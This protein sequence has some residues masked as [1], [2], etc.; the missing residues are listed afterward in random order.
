MIGV[1]L[2]GKKKKTGEKLFS[3]GKEGIAGTSSQEIQVGIE[4]EGLGVCVEE[5]E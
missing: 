2:L 1:L 5:E 4:A 3:L